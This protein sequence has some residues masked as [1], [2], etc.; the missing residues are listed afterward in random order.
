LYR[1]GAN[2]PRQIDANRTRIARAAT[3]NTSCR[4]TAQFNTT[5]LSGGPIAARSFHANLFAKRRNTPSPRCGRFRFSKPP[6]CPDKRL[7][8]TRL[9]NLAPQLC[10]FS[11]GESSERDGGLRQTQLVANFMQPLRSCFKIR[12]R[13]SHPLPG[14]RHL[15]SVESRIPILQSFSFQVR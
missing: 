15:Q 4:R 7:L 11:R 14:F 2:L 3:P 13:A 12:H 8:P 10:S 1:L 9:E 5:V 6:S